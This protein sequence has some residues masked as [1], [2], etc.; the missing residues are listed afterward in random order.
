MLPWGLDV[1]VWSFPSLRLPSLAVRPLEPLVEVFNV[2]DPHVWAVPLDLVSSPGMLRQ[3]A[4]QC[5]LSQSRAVIEA[6]ISLL[7]PFTASVQEVG[8]DCFR[9]WQAARWLRDLLH[10]L[11]RHDMHP[12]AI[13]GG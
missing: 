13:R 9:P 7:F 4:E 10:F 8:H 2:F 3:V 12:S 1:E 5:E 11:H 6:R